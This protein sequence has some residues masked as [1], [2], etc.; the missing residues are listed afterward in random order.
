MEQAGVSF[1]ESSDHVLTTRLPEGHGSAEMISYGYHDPFMLFGFL[2]ERTTLDFATPALVLP[3]RP[4]ALAAKQMAGLVWVHGDRFR[5]GLGSGWN[6]PQF[7]ALGIAFGDLG[8]IL[9]ERVAV[10]TAAHRS[11]AETAP[12]PRPRRCPG[13]AG[14]RDATSRRDHRGRHCD[15]LDRVTG[16]AVDCSRTPKN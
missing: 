10:I 13:T 4:A 11:V 8:A 9:S 15:L 6:A 2:A 14:A 3:Q 12:P 1:L 16:S 5:F 7:A